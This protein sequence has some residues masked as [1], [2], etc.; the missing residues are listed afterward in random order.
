MTTALIISEDIGDKRLEYPGSIVAYLFRFLLTVV[1]LL[2]WFMYPATIYL[3]IVR[4]AFLR[5]L[6]RV[7]PVSPIHRDDSKK[8]LD[9]EPRISLL[10]CVV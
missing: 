5:I 8:L 6:K 3:R 2:S 7:E 10:C 1:V 9:R 4:I